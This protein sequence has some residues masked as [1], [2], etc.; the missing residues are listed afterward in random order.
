MRKLVVLLGLVISMMSCTTEYRVKKAIEEEIVPGLIDPK[1]YEFYS[2]EITDTMTVYDVNK[3]LHDYK[4]SN[5]ESYYERFKDWYEH[6]KYL[7]ELYT[8]DSKRY[9]N[10]EFYTRRMNEYRD[11]MNRCR[12]D[13]DEAKTKLDELILPVKNDTDSFYVCSFRFKSKTELGLTKLTTTIVR[14]NVENFE[15]GYSPYEIERNKKLE[16]ILGNVK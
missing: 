16:E 3:E 4:K 13:M 1:S 8:D 11:S 6:Y 9:P 5:L 2:M 15:I 10:E 7:Y 14:V 12:K